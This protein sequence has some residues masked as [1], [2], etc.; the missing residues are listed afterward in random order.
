MDS[1]PSDGLAL[2]HAAPAP[3]SPYLSLI[4]SQVIV[5]K[6]VIALALGYTLNASILPT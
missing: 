2:E 6:K 1:D 5:K 4:Y 3:R